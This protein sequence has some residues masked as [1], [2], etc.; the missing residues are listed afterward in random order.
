MWM[1]EI[2]QEQK[3]LF[4]AEPPLQPQDSIYKAWCDDV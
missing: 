2:D 3:V 1:L 4:T